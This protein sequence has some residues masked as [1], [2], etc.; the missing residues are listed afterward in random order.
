MV[1]KKTNNIKQ[2]AYSLKDPVKRTD[3][4]KGKQDSYFS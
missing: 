1:I 2:E 4:A 3:I